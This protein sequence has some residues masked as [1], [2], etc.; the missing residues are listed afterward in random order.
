MKFQVKTAL[1]I[2]TFLLLAPAAMAQLVNGSFEDP[3]MTGPYYLLP[4]NSTD[5]PGWTTTDSGVEWFQTVA[6]GLGGAPDGVF[7]VDLANY[8]YSAGG[9]M[10]TFA[11]DPGT[12]YHINFFLGTSESSGRD[13]TCEIVV[14]ADGQSE[15]FAMVNHTPALVWED[16]TFVFT[17][18]D[19]STE[20]SFRCLQDAGYHFAFIDAVGTAG[21]VATTDKTW[22]GV[23]S[24]YR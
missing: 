20:L 4:G 10:Q 7:V 16:K 13:G 2:L 15:T 5:I 19:T 14:E 9:I 24:L 11:T 23:K 6:Y 8:T 18:D 21:T 1:L 12:Q 22:A 3:Q 17:A